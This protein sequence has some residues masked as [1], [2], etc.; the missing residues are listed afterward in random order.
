MSRQNDEVFQNLLNEEGDSGFSS[1][2]ANDTMPPLMS[3]SSSETKEELRP[4]NQGDGRGEPPAIDGVYERRF[5]INR[6]DMAR[7]L[8]RF[9]L[10]GR[11]PDDVWTM[12]MKT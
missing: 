12:R 6:H 10:S 3:N 1:S 5:R 9:R 11:L 7:H 8:E 4:E 2:D